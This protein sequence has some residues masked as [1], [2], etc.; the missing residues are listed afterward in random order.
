MEVAF[1]INLPY[2]AI[3]LYD[4]QHNHKTSTKLSKKISKAKTMY[5]FDSN[6]NISKA[7]NKQNM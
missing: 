1:P 4:N 2:S 7:V 5:K 3:D 6:A